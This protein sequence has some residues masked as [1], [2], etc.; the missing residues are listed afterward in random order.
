M[1]TIKLQ[2]REYVKVIDRLKYFNENH[3][4]GTINTKYEIV[5]NN[6]VF[7]AEIYI[8]GELQTTGHA[9]KS[10]AKEFELEKC[11]TRAIG[12]ALGIFGIGADN[13][14]STYDEVKEAISQDIPQNTQTKEDQEKA[15]KTLIDKAK[16]AYKTVK[17][18]NDTIKE[19]RS[20]IEILENVDIVKG[21]QSIQKL[22]QGQK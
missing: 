14:I 1:K 21:M 11:E 17:D 12:R 20:Q 13:S 4:D 5:G 2:G 9:L 19:W 16:K 22:I 15:R 10:I 18:P 6:V 3:K 7:T 8:N